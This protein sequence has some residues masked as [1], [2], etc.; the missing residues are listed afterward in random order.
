MAVAEASDPSAIGPRR[1]E[2]LISLLTSA[3]PFPAIER[4]EL[5]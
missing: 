2:A 5:L 4:P 1:G 3:G